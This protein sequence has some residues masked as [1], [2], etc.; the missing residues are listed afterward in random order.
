[1]WGQNFKV[2]ITKSKKKGYK[3]QDHKDI[4]KWFINA[5]QCMILIY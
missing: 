2:L 5:E 3:D 4:S 1:M